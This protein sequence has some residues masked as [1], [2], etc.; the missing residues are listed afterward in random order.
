[1]LVRHGL[2]V[3]SGPNDGMVLPFFLLFLAAIPGTQ[4][5]EE[6]VVGV[7]WQALVLSTALGL[8]VG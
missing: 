3:E 6:G 2:N 8:L 1:M 5:A 7:F 4:Y